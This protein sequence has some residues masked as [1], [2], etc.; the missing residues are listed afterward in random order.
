MK[1]KILFFAAG[2]VVLVLMY[3]GIQQ[4]TELRALKREIRQMFFSAIRP[5]RLSNC[6]L[7][8]F[9]PQHDGGYLMCGNLLGDAQSAYSYGIAGDDDWGCDISKKYH[10]PVHQYDCFDPRRPTCAGGQF[11]FHDECVAASP[12]R[13]GKRVFDSVANQIARNGDVGKRLVVKMDVEGAELDVL[14]AMPDELLGR[15]DQLVIE[16]H[17][18]D[19]PQDLRV[20]EKLERTFHIVYVHSNNYACRWGEPPFSSGANEVLFVNKRLAVLDG[21]GGGPVWVSPLTVPNYPDLPECQPKW[22]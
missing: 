22:P 6:T 17:S 18:I 16:L 7:E 2:A 8:R 13:D 19:K 12:E 15:I 4:W 5:V 3:L 20:M 11:D 14:E 10:L 1:R 21:T 9:G